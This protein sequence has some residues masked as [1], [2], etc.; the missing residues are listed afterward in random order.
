LFARHHFA[1]SFGERLQD[2]ERLLL[3]TNAHFATLE[4]A[5]L[6]IQRPSIEPDDPKGHSRYLQIRDK[7]AT[8]Q[9]AVTVRPWRRNRQPEMLATRW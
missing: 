4:L 2:L 5:G 1:G 7:S 6:R 3:E 8:N 9:I